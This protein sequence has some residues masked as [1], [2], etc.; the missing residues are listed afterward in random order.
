MTK[1]LLLN[2]YV[3]PA[4][5]LN[6]LAL[7]VVGAED[8]L[9]QLH[10]LEGDEGEGEGLHGVVLLLCVEDHPVRCKVEAALLLPLELDAILT[11]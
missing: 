10:V 11:N 7:D 1:R 6:H 5:A 3:Q 2:T 9:L 8:W 4:S